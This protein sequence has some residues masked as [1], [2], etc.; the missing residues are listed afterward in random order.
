M[1]PPLAVA[2]MLAC[3][4]A[5]RGEQGTGLLL[6]AETGEGEWKPL[7]DSLAAKGAIRADF[8]ERRFFPFRRQPM[9]LNGVLRISPERGLSLE[10]TSPERNVLIADSAGL[11]LKD[12]GGRR[13]EMPAG[14]RALAAIESLLPIMRFDLAALYPRFVIRASRSGSNWTFVF[15]PRDPE[16]AGSLGAITV[17]GEGSEVLQ[18]EFRRSASQRVEITVGRTEAGTAFS[19]AELKEFFR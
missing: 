3:L 5:A 19:P 9:L 10:Y 13:R 17:G 11:L 12:A 16:T 8:A 15:T 14:S 1:R 6:S 18:L 4:C 2:L 7:I